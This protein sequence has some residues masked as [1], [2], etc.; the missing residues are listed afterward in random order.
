MAV[1]RKK[2][3]P[4]RPSFNPAGNYASLAQYHVEDIYAEVEANI[5]VEDY[6]GIVAYLLKQPY[7]KVKF[8]VDKA[9]DLPM[10]V[11]TVASALLKDVQYGRIQTTQ[12]ALER[13][14]G[15][16]IERQHVAITDNTPLT[17]EVIDTSDNQEI[18][19][20]IAK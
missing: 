20:L 15:K 6:D 14:K 1:R 2:D 17:I 18:E 19:K 10:I 13:L 8:C 9:K 5:D 7:S 16:P 12:M 11:K 3:E 4:K